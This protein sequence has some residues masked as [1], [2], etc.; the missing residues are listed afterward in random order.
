MAGIS[1]DRSV[2][3]MM[4]TAAINGTRLAYRDEGTG[5][6][7]VFIHGGLVADASLPLVREPELLS[8]YRLISYHRRGFGDSA[9]PAEPILTEQQAADCL[10]L[11]RHLGI[12]SAH[13]AGYSYG[14]SIALQLALDAPG[15]VRSLALFEPLVPAAMAD[16]ETVKYF[17]DAVQ[18]AFGLY[19]EGNKQAAIDRFAQGA[20]GKDYRPRLEAALP[21]GF[22]R[23]VADADV[24]FQVEMPA[25]QQWQF[26]PQQA[27][28]ITVPV[29]AAYH[30]DAVWDGFRQTQTAVCQWIARV[31]PLRLPAT[32]HL[33]QILTPGDAAR[34]LTA[35]LGQ[36]D[37]GNRDAT[38]QEHVAAHR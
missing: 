20:F 1:V 18:E 12:E 36:Q 9:H 27:A 8:R 35:F 5:E 25:I 28:R 15:A 29:L 10:A 38:Q 31:Q 19:A 3:G 6:P 33:L 2:S 13:L 14:G 17:M 34:G 16:A 24:L 21:G 7:I 32:S 37:R 11:M 30:D 4:N 22:E 26:G 23:M